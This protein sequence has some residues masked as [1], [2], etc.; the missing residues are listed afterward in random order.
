MPVHVHDI[1]AHV[2]AGSSWRMSMTVHVGD[3]HERPVS[4]ATVHAAF[5]GGQ[6]ITCVTNLQG[7]CTVLSNSRSG[8]ATVYGW[9]RNITRTQVTYY[10]GLNHDID[11]NTNGTSTSVTSSG[12][13]T[14]TSTASQTPTATPT[15]TQVP[16]G[17][18]V[19]VHDIDAGVDTAIDWW[20]MSMTVWVYD[21]NGQPVGGATVHAG[22]TGG[23]LS[24]CV[25][26]HGGIC[27]VYSGQRVGAATVYGWVRNITRSGVKY[28]GAANHDADGG[29]NGTS[30]SVSGP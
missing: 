14:P 4:G 18:R 13:M 28:H 16:G 23:H 6:L 24:T 19:H 20:R 2:V 11:G 10:P 22:F 12:T 30:T 3:A 27:T 8:A 15:P 29:T 9:V 5:T 1:D 25:T 21:A 26:N 7:W 17:V